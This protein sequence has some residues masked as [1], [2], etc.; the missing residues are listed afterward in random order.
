MKKLL[1]IDG[2]SLASRAFHAN[3]G[4]KG[5][6]GGNI[7]LVKGFIGGLGNLLQTEMPDGL[8]IA[9]DTNKE[10][11]WRHEMDPEYKATRG[12]RPDD[13]YPQLRDLFAFL[14]GYGFKLFY[15]GGYE[16]DDVIATLSRK[17]DA[18]EILIATQD[19]DMHQL[20]NEKVS[21]ISLDKMGSKGSRITVE[22]FEEV[23]GFPPEKYLYYKAMVGDTSDNIKGLQG[24][25]PKRASEI[26]ALIKDVNNFFE[27][28]KALPV[29]MR[30]YFED[31][32]AKKV[33]EK[34][35]KL[36]SLSY[37][38]P[39]ESLD[40]SL[41]DTPHST[42]TFRFTSYFKINFNRAFLKPYKEKAVTTQA[43][44]DT[45]TTSSPEPE[46]TMVAEE[47]ACAVV[48]TPT[49]PR[50]FCA[51][52]T[53]FAEVKNGVTRI[54]A[55]TAWNLGGMSLM[56]AEIKN[57]TDEEYA[58]LAKVLAEIVAQEVEAVTQT[59]HPRIVGHIKELAKSGGKWEAH[60]DEIR[61]MAENNQI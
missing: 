8:A 53:I 57:H 34:A 52:K 10:K 55:K 20:V 2:H 49:A 5:V 60:E 38:V 16:G 23:Y 61:K 40:C 43:T 58:P 6:D 39:F 28:A 37:D 47:V 29:N 44:A 46:I 12:P 30:K 19:S 15:K 31:T 21:V 35:L 17:A 9:F 42:E 48:Q 36:V 33:F 41:P 26:L 7:G 27:E 3:L 18:E 51:K 32:E 59:L 13:F 45:P 50:V 25:G 4:H 56:V 24:V 22:N 11:T 14:R 1:I 54:Y